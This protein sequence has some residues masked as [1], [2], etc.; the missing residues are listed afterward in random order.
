MKDAARRA[1]TVARDSAR[2]VLSPAG[3]RGAGVEVVWAAAHAALYPLGALRERTRKDQ[4]R[5]SLRGLNP[6]KR[7]LLLGDV[8]A[9]GTPIV[10]V[11]GWVD[12]RSIFTVLRRALHRRGF[13]QVVTMNYNVLTHDVPRAAHRL[14]ALVEQVCDQTGYERVHVVGH[15]MGGLVARYYVQR[16]GGDE[17][18]HTLA[19][20]GTPHRGTRAAHLFVGRALKSL[21]VG[22]SVVRELEEPAP[23][24]RTRFLA[25]WSDLDE[26]VVPKSSGRIDHP[27]LNA[28]NVFIRGA[29]HLSLPIDGRV[30]HEIVSAF[31]LLDVDGSTLAAGMITVDGAV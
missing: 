27:D 24:C 21:R 7:G 19:T 16:L 11:H 12:N 15:S 28:R 8:E 29:G 3:L 6:V 20:L 26:L 14:G 9:A 22:S 4:A 23:H 18:I 31:A 1:G 25:F 30:V 13:G 17:R 2:A 10:L 5:Y